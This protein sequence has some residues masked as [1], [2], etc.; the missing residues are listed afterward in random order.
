[1]KQLDLLEWAEARPTAEILDWH[2]PFAKRA[3]SRI[4]EY[5]DDWPKS[6]YPESV[7]SFPSR[8]KG[9]A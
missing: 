5:D 1:M 9:A 8:K 2:A 6:F 7:I 4:H 3:M